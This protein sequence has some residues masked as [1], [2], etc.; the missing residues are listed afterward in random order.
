MAV[1]GDMVGSRRKSNRAELQSQLLETLDHI[2][3]DHAL[4]IASK[5][6]V[7]IGDEF[8]GLLSTP[9]RWSDIIDQ[10]ARHL[11]KTNFRF[12]LGYGTLSTALQEVAL[13]MDGPAW[14][15]A[16]EGVENRSRNR[17]VAIYKGFGDPQ[18][19]NLI[20][21]HQA[22]VQLKMSLTDK[23]RDVVEKLQQSKTH[24]QVAHELG[25]LRTDVT[26]TASRANF[27]TIRLIRQAWVAQLAQFDLK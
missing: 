16:R 17:P 10:L 1:I 14:H 22:Y 8:Q 7:T 19:L 24:K 11:P 26:H 20:A 2:N 15:L 9:S 25:I 6:T 5:F 12:G 21:H 18:N 3:R 23:Q 13:Q 27:E 4:A